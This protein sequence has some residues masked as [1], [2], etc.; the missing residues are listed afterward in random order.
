MDLN[1]K[2]NSGTL[3]PIYLGAK[4][5]EGREPVDR[6]M[7]WAGFVKKDGGISHGDVRNDRDKTYK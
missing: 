2:S 3:C 1:G 6:R 4:S 5:G 7:K